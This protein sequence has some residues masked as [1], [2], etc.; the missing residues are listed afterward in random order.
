MKEHVDFIKDSF[1]DYAG[2]VHHFVIAALSQELPTCTC[3]LEEHNE[4]NAAI[5]YEV[6]RYVDNYGHDDY[7]GSVTKVLKLGVSICNPTDKFDEGV[8]A[9]KALSRARNS[10]PTLYAAN[11]G[12][13]NTRVVKALLEQEA[14][15]LKN[16]PERFI[17]GYSDMK[18]RYETNQKMQSVKEEFSELEKQVVENLEKDPKFLDKA[19][20]YLE[21]VRKQRIGSGCK[22]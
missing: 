11:P 5:I 6:N 15:Y 17:V 16:N 14:L 4:D 8:G 13:I 9:H 3:Q 7:L 20:R 2:K 12:V 10:A 18:E 21:W 19:M 1:V 22:E